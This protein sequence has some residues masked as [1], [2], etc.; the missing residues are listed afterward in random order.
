LP[1]RF[2]RACN[3]FPQPEHSSLIGTAPFLRFEM[4]LIPLIASTPAPVNS[5]PARI[6]SRPGSRDIAGKRQENRE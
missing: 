1:A 2:S 3:T 6:D 5:P 4:A